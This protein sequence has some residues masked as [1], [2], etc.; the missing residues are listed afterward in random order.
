M[1]QNEKW[2][3][4]GAILLALVAIGLAMSNKP[5]DGHNRASDALDQIRSS[6]LLKA[7]FISYPPFSSQNPSSGKL[8][9]IAIDLVEKMAFEADWN[10]EFVETDWGNL[11]L[12]L[13]SK[14]CDVVISGIFP[15]VERASGGTMFSK[16]MGFVGN[17]VIVKSGDRRFTTL[18]DL[19]RPDVTIAVIAGEQGHRFAQKSLTHAKLDVISS[20]DISLALTEVS[21]GRADAAMGDMSVIVPFVRAHPETRML[22]EKP[23]W[24]RALT[25]AMREDD[26]KLI[27]FV[28]VALDSMTVSGDL[29][30]II[31]K[32]PHEGITPAA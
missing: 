15:L 20:G 7:C 4:I 2:L 23:Y 28:N 13:N 8:E 14:R 25:W 3:V 31:A 32:Y 17:N 1:E 24:N 12:A 9:G 16:P 5:D 10:I 27:N 26:L 19:D 11:S 22:L 6:K 21:A 18:S 29:N 30:E